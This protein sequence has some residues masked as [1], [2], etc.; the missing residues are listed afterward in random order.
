MGMGGPIGLDFGA[1]IQLASL[2]GVTDDP[3]AVDLFADLLPDVERA[4]L[5]GLQPED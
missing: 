4:I 1:A 5:I 2:S 3:I